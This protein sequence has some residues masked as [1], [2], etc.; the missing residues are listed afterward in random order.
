MIDATDA[1]PEATTT[2]T[3]VASVVCLNTPTTTLSTVAAATTFTLT[4]TSIILTT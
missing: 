4:I 1:I 3:N 2:K